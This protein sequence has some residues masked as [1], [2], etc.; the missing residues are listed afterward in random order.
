MLER[1]LIDMGRMAPGSEAVVSV[2]LRDEGGEWL[3]TR[4]A[5][6]GCRCVAGAMDGQLHGAGEEARPTLNVRPLKHRDPARPRS[7]LL[8]TT[9]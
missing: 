8:R 1:L 5:E 2:G 3:T 4:E 9:P 6:T 7:P